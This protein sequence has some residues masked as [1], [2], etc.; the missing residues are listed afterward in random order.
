MLNTPG[1]G[2][3]LSE[4]SGRVRQHLSVFVDGQRLKP[5]EWVATPL[6]DPGE[7]WILRAVSG[8]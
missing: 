8:G 2:S 1:M 4:S 3:W 7:V 6:T 5:R